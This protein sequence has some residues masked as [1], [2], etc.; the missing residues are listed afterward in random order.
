MLSSAEAGPLAISRMPSGRTAPV[1]HHRD[2]L[3][4][5][6]MGYSGSNPRAGPALSRAHATRF[7]NP[8]LILVNKLLTRACRARPV[9]RVHHVP[10]GPAS[11]LA[12]RFR[13][14]T[15][16]LG[17]DVET[18]FGFR[19][20]SAS[21]YIVNLRRGERLIFSFTQRD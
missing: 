8:R 12:K 2:P 16:W 21:K 1:V 11:K 9:S 14:R 20:D 4:L 13:C 6:M 10:H 17:E 18:A 15:G 19:K 3:T 5:G 7:I